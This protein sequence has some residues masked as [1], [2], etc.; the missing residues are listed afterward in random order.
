MI[1]LPER[2]SR[3]VSLPLHDEIEQMLKEAWVASLGATGI[4]VFHLIRQS[5][6]GLPASPLA[7]R[8]RRLPLSAKGPGE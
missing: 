4:F 8:A 6:L 5:R 7:Q 2:L 1:F 3:F